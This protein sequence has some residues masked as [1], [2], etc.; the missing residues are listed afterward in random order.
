MSANEYQIGGTHYNRG[1]QHWDYVISKN[2]PYLEAMIIKYVERHAYKNGREDL[3]KA[4]HF[5]QKAL[6]TY[7]PEGDATSA[8]VDQD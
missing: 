2:I 8:Y 7:Y 6:E 1:I 3:L 4:R 5:L